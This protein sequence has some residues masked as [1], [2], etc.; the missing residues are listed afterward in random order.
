MS[1]EQLPRHVILRIHE[2]V[3]LIGVSHDHIARE[4]T[5]DAVPSPSGGTRWDASTIRAVLASKAA[6]D[7]VAPRTPAT[8]TVE[9]FDDPAS[10]PFGAATAIT[11]TEPDG[12]VGVSYANAAGQW[13]GCAIGHTHPGDDVE[14]PSSTDPAKTPIS[15]EELCVKRKNALA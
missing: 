4:L 14:E 10:A 6:A 9:H 11:V 8:M 12:G 1:T 15:K 13:V 5:E 7:A 2:A 3:N